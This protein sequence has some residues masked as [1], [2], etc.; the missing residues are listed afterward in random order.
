MLLKKR[1]NKWSKRDD[2]I[3]DT[4]DVKYAIQIMSDNPSII[5]RPFFDS[6]ELSYIKPLND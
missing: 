5:K 3:N 2:S 1:D 6:N 4:V